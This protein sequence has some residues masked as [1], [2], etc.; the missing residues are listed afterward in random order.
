VNEP[1][2]E[3]E[4]GYDVIVAWALPANSRREHDNELTTGGFTHRF[5]VSKWIH[6]N[7]GDAGL[8]RFFERVHGALVPGGTFVFEAQPRESYIKARKLHPVRATCPPIPCNYLI[9][10]SQKLQENAQTLQ[11]Q[12]EGFERVLCSIGFDP[13]QRLG[14]PGEGREY[15]DLWVNYCYSD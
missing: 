5:S 3:D 8:Q 12:P 9:H 11:I 10:F 6:L 13:A 15:L 14:E 4:T 1:I 2:P 7:G